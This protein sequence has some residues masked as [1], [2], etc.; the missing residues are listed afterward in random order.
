MM[1]QALP[2]VGGVFKSEVSDFYVEEIPLNTLGKKGSHC[3]FLIE[4]KG[5]TTAEA[6]E[7]IA[8][9]VGKRNR[10]IGYAG[11]KDAH[12]VTRQWISLERVPP[13]RVR[14][15]KLRNIR[16]LDWGRCDQPLKIG[17]LKGN[18][19]RVRIREL[20]MPVDQAV[21]Q[22]REI[23]SVLCERGMPNA[24]GPQR[25]GNRDNS[26]VLG[27]TILMGQ[28]E[29]FMDLLMGD[30]RAL[31]NANEFRVR[32][33]YSR[34]QFNK[35]LKICP[36]HLTDTR[37]V[38]SAL[39]RHRGDKGKAFDC[40]TQGRLRFLVSAYQSHLFNEVLSARMP[41]MDQ[42]LTGDIAYRH[43]DG[44]CFS[45][46]NPALEQDR[47]TR[48]E[49]S[50]TGPIYSPV[51][52]KPHGQAGKIENIVLHREQV[53]KLAKTTDLQK[54][55]AK[56][57]RRPFRVQPIHASVSQGRNKLGDYLEVKFDLPSGS[58]ATVLLREIMK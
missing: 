37:R 11:L 48:F 17:G 43:S 10:D 34:G 3:Y 36:A 47:C 45:V 41:R 5:I 39:V 14:R 28:R 24:F 55:L 33:L 4:K 9:A 56:G 46:E 32:T 8:H 2:G 6:V 18:R 38:L 53:S 20:R 35:A 30:P 42:C 49:I 19:F 22:A 25:F 15:L 26:H 58:Y 31:D 54:Y 12:A 29:A 1:T 23:M 27:K 40:V 52:D 16:I 21:T 50:P 7:T 51:M 44:H 57:G 13:D